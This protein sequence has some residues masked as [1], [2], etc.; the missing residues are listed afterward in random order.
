MS[1]GIQ[2][3][4]SG[5]KGMLDPFSIDPCLMLLSAEE[6]HVE[7]RCAYGVWMQKGGG[8]GGG[9][10]GVYGY[11]YVLLAPEYRGVY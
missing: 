2:E 5:A 7:L 1:L 3:E 9:S 4:I 6:M 11:R 10:V 8:Y